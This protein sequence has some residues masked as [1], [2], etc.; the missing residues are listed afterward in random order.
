MY[1]YFLGD[2][3]SAPKQSKRLRKNRQVGLVFHIFGVVFRKI[4]LFNCFIMINNYYSVCRAQTTPTPCAPS[5]D[6]GAG[7]SPPLALNTPAQD[8]VTGRCKLRV[9]NYNNI[10][11]LAAS[12]CSLYIVIPIIESHFICINISA[13]TRQ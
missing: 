7:Q 12:V 4:E 11:Y 5:Y 1:V 10:F 8:A 6:L 3:A 13:A 2:K 9:N